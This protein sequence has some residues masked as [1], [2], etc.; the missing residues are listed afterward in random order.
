MFLFDLDHDYHELHNLREAQPAE[1]TRTHACLL[2]HAKSYYTILVFIMPPHACQYQD[3]MLLRH[4]A[5]KR[6]CR[7]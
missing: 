1:F 2:T 3:V 7:P 4:C 6:F 5:I